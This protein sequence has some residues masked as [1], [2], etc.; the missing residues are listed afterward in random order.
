MCSPQRR[1]KKFRTACISPVV[2]PA[3][4][5]CNLLSISTPVH[6]QVYLKGFKPDVK[7]LQEHPGVLF[8]YLSLMLRNQKNKLMVP[9]TKNTP[10]KRSEKWVKFCRAQIHQVLLPNYHNINHRLYMNTTLLNA[11]FSPPVQKLL[12]LKKK[13]SMLFFYLYL[14]LGK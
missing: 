6:V 2:S 10:Q 5:W 3:G 13:K 1:A 7:M 14:L 4:L 11:K 9:F 8:L 12:V